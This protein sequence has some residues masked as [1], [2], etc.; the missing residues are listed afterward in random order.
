[1]A[2]GANVT[3]V[4]RQGNKASGL[5][6]MQCS[7]SAPSSC[8]SVNV[9]V[10]DHMG[11]VILAAGGLS[12]PKVLYFSGIGPSDILN[13][14]GNAGQLTM[15]QNDWIVNE[16]VGRGL[17]DSPD[18]F[19]MLQSPSVQSYG[20]G[21]NGQ[22]VD[23]APSDLSDY[24]QHRSGSYASTGKTGVFW[25]QF[26]GPDGRPVAVWS[27]SD[28]TNCQMQGTISSTGHGAYQCPGCFTMNVYGTAGTQSRGRVDLDNNWIPT[29]SN[30]TYYQS[31]TTDAAN[32]ASYIHQ[33]LQ[34]INGTNMTCLNIPQNASQSQIQDY[35]TTNSPYAVVPT[36]HW[37]GS[38]SMSNDCGSGVVSPNSK[39]CGM[40]NLYIADA[41]IIPT[42]FTVSP[43]F[44][45]MVAGEHAS[46]NIIA[47]RG[48]CCGCLGQTSTGCPSNSTSPSTTSSPSAKSVASSL[49]SP[50]VTFAF[51][52]SAVGVPITYF[53]SR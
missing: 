14:L 10:S 20:F 5:E 17:F 8:Q 50:P 12:T 21:Y 34:S 40:Q 6:V 28:G 43:Q 7:P 49:H 15:P 4:I 32:A 31:N 13:R 9:S 22:G 46:D 48:D 1:M 2:Q 24:S 44:G 30:D 52:I 42:P 41:G 29:P 18:T 36:N 3:R 38:T 47:D 45:I 16:N 27:R 33:L 53:L 26:K 19:V 23:V 35:I 51:F 39:V 25:D 11:Q 37:G